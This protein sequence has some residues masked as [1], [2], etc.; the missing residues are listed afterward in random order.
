MAAEAEAA[1]WVAEFSAAAE[2]LKTA[3]ATTTQAA[4]L[5]FEEWYDPIVVAAMATEMANLSTAAQQAAAGLTAQYAT[6]VVAATAA[7]IVIP[8]P[9]S[10]FMRIRNGV[11]LALVHSRPA[12]AYKKAIAT[13]STHAE[14]LVKAGI[15]AAGLALTDLSLQEREVQREILTR[16][17]IT[18]YRRVIRPELSKTGTCGLCIV[19]ADRI[20]STGD[21]MPLHPPSCKCVTMP[22][23][24]D[25]D[26]GQSL[27]REDLDQLYAD[28]GSN[29]ADD[30]RRT[31][32][33]VNQHGEH[34]P[35]L[36]KEGDHFRGPDKV[37][38]EDD[39]ERA[40]RMLDQVLP[41]LA[42]LEAAGG[43]AGPL[44]Y[45]RK[46][47]ARLRRIAAA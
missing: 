5:A 6:Q 15:R 3:T 8:Q 27:N 25:N 43:P 29:K 28:A 21:L 47:A 45:Q 14:A 11:S 20:Y 26:P 19:A 10:P 9:R 30:L 24:G 34:G 1:I 35:V 39:P 7:T 18:Q 32:Y 23:I 13:G 4:W 42:R 46:L 2:E 38:L 40:A 12:E 36:S 22:I 16:A 37:A 41:V 44:T 17:G 33:V 31:R